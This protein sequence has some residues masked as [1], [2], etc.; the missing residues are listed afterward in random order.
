M[1]LDNIKDA[2][3]PEDALYAMFAGKK[4]YAPL[5]AGVYTVKI[6]DSVLKLTKASKP[7]ISIT[8]HIGE[9]PVTVTLFAHENFDNVTRFASSY[10][11][12]NGQEGADIVTLLKEKPWVGKDFVF[13]Y[14]HQVNGEYDDCNWMVGEHASEYVKEDDSI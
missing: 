5:D 4:A 1:N 9:R 14:Q 7:F 2:P 10:A 3:K 8:G 11:L 12:A 13:T 6:E